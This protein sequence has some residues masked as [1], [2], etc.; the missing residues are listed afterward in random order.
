MRRGARPH[1]RRRR[2]GL[3]ASDCGRAVGRDGGARR[4]RRPVAPARHAHAVRRLEPEVC[5]AV[6]ADGRVPRE[7]LRERDAGGIGDAL[8]RVAVDDDVPGVAGGGLS[9]VRRAG[10]GGAGRRRC[11][12]G[13]RCGR[14]RVVGFLVVG[15]AVAEAGREGAG[16]GEV[17]AEAGVPDA[18]VF[19]RDVVHVGGELAVVGPARGRQVVLVV[20]AG[21][22]GGA[23]LARAI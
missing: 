16:G 20:V 17:V 21:E 11:G 9:R 18:E 1:L 3:R 22:I 8:A 7:E 14:G 6:A 2:R 10:G 13:G 12:G 19:E 23:V 15:A 4:G 5:A